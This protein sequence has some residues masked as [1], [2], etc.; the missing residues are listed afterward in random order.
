VRALGATLITVLP[1]VSP[2]LDRLL[3]TG[4][5]PEG[6]RPRLERLV[7]AGV[8]LPEDEA[9]LRLLVALLSSG[10]FLT[11]LLLVDVERLTALLADP[12]LDRPKPREQTMAE[13]RA[14]LAGCADLAD[15]QRR[16]RRFRQVEMLRLGA[17]ELKPGA[18]LEVARDLSAL[19]DACLDAA[20]AFCESQLRAGYGDPVCAED[21]PGFVVVAMGKLGGE[22]LN[23]SSDVDLI[24]VY[25]SDE[26]H[27]GSLSLHEY[28][29]RLSQMVTRAVAEITGDGFV[30]RVDLRLRPEGGS[31][32]IC[33]SL[34]AAESYYE[35]F[36]RT[37]ERQALLRARPAA[38]DL[39][40]GARFLK[41]VEPFVFPR[42]SGPR[43]LDEVRSL[44]QQFV[45]SARHPG[46]D[47]K[48]GQGGIRDVELVAQAL[49][50]LYAGKRSDLRERAT[51]PALHKLGLAGLLTA[52]EVR[53]LSHAY[54]FLRSVEHRI[55]LEQGAQTH[56]LPVE[57]RAR[58]RLARR[59]GLAGH[60]EL[61]ALVAEQRQAVSAVAETLGEPE[62]GPSAIVLR[63]LDP[64][65]PRPYLLADLQSCGFSD[66][67]AAA[68]SLELVRGRL[69][70]I[71][72][73][74][75]IASPNP[76]RALDRFRDLSLRASTGLETM[77]HE[78]RQLLTML[79]ALFGTSERLSRHLLTHPATWPNLLAGPGDARPD[80]LE[81]QTRLPARLAG[82]DYE[83]ALR[84]VRRFQAEEILR[85]GLHDVAGNL[86]HQEVSA[87]LVLLAEACLAQAVVRVA[88]ELE[89]R[90][91]KPD[92]ELTIL[93]LGSCGAREMRYGSDLE[94]VFLYQHEGIT[95]SGIEYQ[96]WF[97][98][99]AQRL[100]GALG[101]LL[102]EGRLYNVDTRLRPSGSQ[103]LLVTTYQAFEYYH[104]E[105][106]APWERMALLRARPAFVLPG[107][108]APSDFAN[109]L[110][111]IAYQTPPDEDSLRAGL[112]H[113][114][115]RIE[116]E[117]A[118]DPRK[119]LHLRFAPGGLTDLE[120]LAA[121]GQ[122]RHGESDPTLRTTHPPAALRRMA[123]R[124]E[125]AAG[126]LDDYGFLQRAGLRLR[127]LRDQHDDR[128]Q[129]EDRSSLARS[130]GMSEAQLSAQLGTRMAR[131]R[132][133]F[134]RRLG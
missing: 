35:S 4:P 26:G 66:V 87:Q 19:A 126:V 78:D 89:T 2:I 129:A 72:L 99:L 24:Y 96:D 92:A 88:A 131:V 69:A 71:W 75:A 123:E 103:G 42:S 100:I 70:P 8:S 112:L 114:R 12:F 93:V 29:G 45:D 84:E 14:A 61:D 28:Y 32:A 37:W 34:A 65:V 104:H 95:A 113:L 25:S 57:P 91:G 83:E 102:E 33:N 11:D 44:R 48:L 60:A 46:W 117:R 106:A 58:D 41:T 77:L 43:T 63:L 133:E 47:V 50:L 111:A 68:E 125:L 107:A 55:Q 118:G 74:Q 30:F 21:S 127:L 9:S 23:F 120:F 85:I 130:L 27:A 20:V 116:S 36:G 94:L 59:L 1:R 119:S 98:R 76:D 10:S 67:A 15:V 5:D 109:R 13:V 7:E 3:A 56:E 51:L 81:W 134:V 22:E 73:E 132:A 62:Q 86:A 108:G 54:H 39:T 97:G 128:L 122:L 90:T 105:S 124:G 38:G 18:S 110:E 17:R 121:W 6:A 40:L 115:Q 79:A 53:T 64:A 49:Q 52:Q 80:P 31:G 16:L 101:A 82:C